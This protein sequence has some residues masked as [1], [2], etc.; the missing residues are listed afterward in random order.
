[1]GGALTLLSIITD[2]KGK[3]LLFIYLVIFDLRFPFNLWKVVCIFKFRKLHPVAE[4]L[5]RYF[6]SRDPP[7]VG[8]I[9]KAMALHAV[10]HEEGQNNSTPSRGE[11]H[12][13][14]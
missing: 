8:L 5:L 12:W 4:K 9:T 3:C 11:G 7:P 6:V 13:L 2:C 10:Q 1:M 14:S